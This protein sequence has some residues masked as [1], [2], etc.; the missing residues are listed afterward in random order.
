MPRRFRTGSRTIAFYRAYPDLTP[1]LPPLA[2]KL[3]NKTRAAKL[4]NK[5]GPTAPFEPP[6]PFSP[7]VVAKITESDARPI[8]QPLVA[9]L[10]R[11]HNVILVRKPT[12]PHALV[13]CS[14]LLPT[15]GA[16]TFS[17]SP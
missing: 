11:A 3:P 12:D 5:M 17:R 4:P 1:I 16:V 8:V 7:P 15:A 14:K 10:P 9:Q 2:A 6:A 13:P